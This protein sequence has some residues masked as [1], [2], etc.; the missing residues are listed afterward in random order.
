M[1]SLSCGCALLAR[2]SGKGC[3]LRP[4]S[5]IGLAVDLQDDRPIDDAVQERHRQRRIT[6]VIGP[7]LEI[8]VRYT[9][10][11]SRGASVDQLVQQACRLGTFGPFNPVETEFIKDHQV[12]VRIVSQPT[13]QRLIGQGRRQIRQH[14]SAG[15]VS[16]AITQYTGLLAHGLD[17]MAL[18]HAAL[19]DHD[20]I[21]FPADEIGP[22]QRLDLEP[23]DG[24][25]LNSQSK[26]ASVLL[27]AKQASR[28]R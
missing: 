11:R 25:A 24:T 9:R 26:S 16:H 3:L 10:R 5:S 1:A 15:R 6:Q 7:G 19:A 22:G 8:D 27:S 20:Q 14:P 2:T 13:R 12:K 17:Q 21:L 18:P 23:I 28:R 4:V